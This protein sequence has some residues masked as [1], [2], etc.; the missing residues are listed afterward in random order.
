MI[1]LVFHNVKLNTIVLFMKNT[2]YHS[3]QEFNTSFLWEIDLAEFE[4]TGGIS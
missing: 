4:R 3:Q 2:F 1:K